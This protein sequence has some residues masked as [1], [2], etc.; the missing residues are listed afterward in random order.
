MKTR[1]LAVGL[2]FAGALFSCSPPP[3]PCEE[4]DLSCEDGGA[5]PPDLCNGREEALS[6]AACKLTLDQAHEAYI[7]FSGDQDWYLVEL[8]ALTARSL[9]NL[10]GGYGAPNTAVNLALNLLRED[11]QVSL[12][13]EVDKHGQSAPKLIDII[14]PFS[15]SNAKLLVLV[16]DEG[17]GLKPNFDVRSPY[18][19]KVRVLENPDVNEPNDSAPTAIPLASSGAVLQ[20]QGTGYLATDDDVDLFSFTAPGGRK[21][22]YLRITAP[23]ISPPPPYRL[24]YVLKNPSGT[25][26]SEGVVA[27]EFLPVD[28]ATAR[29]S[30]AGAYTLE[31]KGYKSTNTTTS[32]AG[33]LRVQYTVSVQ[34]LDDL[35][36]QEPNDTMAAPKVVSM[37]SPG[38]SQSLTGRLAYVPDP[39]WYGIDLGASSQPTVLAY[40]LT[41]SSTAGRFAAL[42]G[43]EDHQLRVVQLV[44]TG[45]TATD[46]QVACKNDPAVCPKGYEGTGSLAQGLVEGL[47]A[48]SDPP[49]CLLSER[50]E[51]PRFDNL[52]NFEGYIPVPP[53]SGT[54][55][56]LLAVQ[57]NATNF[58]DDVEYTLTVR[59]LS[60]A[61]EA[62]RA[63][64]PNQTQ[65]L[66]LPASGFPDPPVAGQVSG[67]LSYGHGRVLS[68]D[69]NQGDGI[70]AP[71]DYDAVVTDFDRFE[72]VFPA[73]PPPEDRTWTISWDVLDLPDGG[74][75]G[76]IALE[77]E[78][79][80]GAG[81]ANTQR[82]IILAYQE[83]RLQPWY[84]G[85]FSARQVLY[86]KQYANGVTTI[87][88]TPNGCFCFE[89]RFVQGGSFWMKVGAIDRE[90]AEPFQYRVRMG[91]AD[92]PQSYTSDGGSFACPYTPDAGP[93]CLF[94]Q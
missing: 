81:C 79:C 65:S 38:S 39:D 18:M 58:A 27:N 93:N 7:S 69:I 8:P 19:V 92:Y 9:V 74:T 85:D 4:G 25:P 3:P 72:Y 6:N 76:D 55:R 46:R 2:L 60:D 47:C 63:G 11:G 61:D 64:L 14:L 13:R 59:W 36:T 34:I 43:L 10:S 42:P 44:T 41:K 70:R 84:T 66:A 29:L 20:G 23:S 32:I 77:M 89:P 73:I 45:A 22:I 88:A 94:G 68:H 15:E 91:Y 16:S 31:I 1:L 17:A 35:D 83:G 56:Y 90:R 67:T 86:D 12:A 49:P 33:D 57:D 37:G 54:V 62:T 40:S 51:A 52:R 87:T 28:L 21:I 53:H 50:N 71:A 30:T 82:N 24:S 78:F 26:V 48:S 80:D 75:P 5:P